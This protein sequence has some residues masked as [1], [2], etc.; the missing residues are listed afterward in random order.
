[1]TT[2]T[3]DLVARLQ[4]QEAAV[5]VADGPGQSRRMSARLRGSSLGIEAPR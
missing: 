1:M 2:A 4:Q 3:A 5:S